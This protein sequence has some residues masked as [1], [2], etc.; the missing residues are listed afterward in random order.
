MTN[1]VRL[2][3]PFFTFVVYASLVVLSDVGSCTGSGSRG[4]GGGGGGGGDGGS[5]SSFDTG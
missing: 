2:L 5:V 1:F 3:Q 4:G